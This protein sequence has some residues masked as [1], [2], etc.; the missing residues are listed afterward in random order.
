MTMVQE[1][2]VAALTVALN[3]YHPETAAHGIRTAPIALRIGLELGMDA[4]E[5]MLLE[6]AGMLHDVGKLHVPFDTL[7]CLTPLTEAQWAEIY[8]HPVAGANLIGSSMLMVETAVRSHHER[9]DGTGYPSGIAGTVIPLTARIVA[10][11]CCWDVMTTG[12]P[13][14]GPLSQHEAADEL[15]KGAGSQFDPGVV[16]AFLGGLRP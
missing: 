16:A 9:W 5:L 6:T 3:V 7:E 13:Y 11:A 2:L 1:R 8:L 4:D 14:K 12:R 10:I 15:R